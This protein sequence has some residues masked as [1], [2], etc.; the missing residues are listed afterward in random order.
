MSRGLGRRAQHDHGRDDHPRGP[1]EPETLLRVHPAGLAPDELAHESGREQLTR[2][3][4]CAPKAL[5]ENR[6][7]RKE[8]EKTIH[9]FIPF[10][11]MKL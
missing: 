8:H 4:D 11:W 2:L 1:G 3:L 7:E 9:F 5:P 10:I 6:E